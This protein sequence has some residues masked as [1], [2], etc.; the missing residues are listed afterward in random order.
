MLGLL[1]INKPL[2]WTSRDVVNR[3][4]RLAGPDKVGHAG[5]LDPLAT[6]VLVVG[7]GGAT[8]LVEYVQQQPKRYRASFRLGESSPSDDLELPTDKLANAP[9]PTLAEVTAA[10]PQ[11]VGEIPQVPPAYSAIKVGGRKSYDL[12]RQGQ[13]VELA[14]RPVTIHAL[15][16]VRYEYPELTLDITCGSGT[17]IRSLG[18]DLAASL[19]T[20]AVMTQLVR[21][22]IGALRLETAVTIEQLLADGLAP[23]LLPARFATQHLPQVP[24]TEAECLELRHGRFLDAGKLISLRGEAA[25]IGPDGELVAV[26]RH[27]NGKLRSSCVLETIQ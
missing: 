4:S 1:N 6:G 14:P 3:V 23:Y 5:T 21:T 7:V 24:L 13:A 8:R 22:A 18:R 20:A 19:G 15:E 26:I 12:A 27:E 10:L 25:G 16:V 2:D 17:Y 9:V 11:F